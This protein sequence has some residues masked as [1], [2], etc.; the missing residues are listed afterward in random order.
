MSD[1]VEEAKRFIDDNVWDG[2]DRIGCASWAKFTPDDLQ[3]LVNDLLE[4]LEI[5]RLRAIE[6]HAQNVVLAN[7]G[8]FECMNGII[9]TR[10][11]VIRKLDEALKDK[12]EL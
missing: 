6:Y 1:I 8:I 11:S 10:E 9:E 4:Y 5:E 12:G 3:E 7:D 2:E